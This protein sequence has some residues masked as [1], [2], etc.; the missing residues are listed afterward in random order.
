MWRTLIGSVGAGIR[1][2]LVNLGRMVIGPRLGY[3]SLL[4]WTVVLGQRSTPIEI[5]K[6]GPSMFLGLIDVVVT[7]VKP[8]DDYFSLL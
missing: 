4:H 7:L 6:L 1:D 2:I 8:T 3:R 5:L